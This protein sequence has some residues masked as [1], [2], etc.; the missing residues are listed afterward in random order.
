MTS[1]VGGVG[2]FVRNGLKHCIIDRYK[3]VSC[4][5]SPVENL[6]MEVT[7]DSNKYIIGGIYR[8]PGHNISDFTQKLDNSL[9]QISNQR[10]PCFIAGDINIDLKRFQSHRDTKAYL[11]SVIVNN[12]SPAVVMPTRITNKN[13]TLIDHIYYS[14]RFN[15]DANKIITGGNLWSDITDHLPNFVFLED[16]GKNKCDFTTLPY[17][18]LYY[19]N[20]ISKFVKSVHNID[21]TELYKYDN[22][23]EAYNFLHQKISHCH[24][25]I[26]RLVRLSRKCANDKL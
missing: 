8:H 3:I 17:V 18:R 25:R 4:S 19:Q 11:D 7:K 10:L 24:S 23:D 13:A 6:W 22:P 20:N 5:N 9:S 12:F 26:F 15:Q 2:I 1:D 14:H 21:W 16:C